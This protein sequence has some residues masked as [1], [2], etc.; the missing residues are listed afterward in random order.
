MGAERAQAILI[1][2]SFTWCQGSTPCGAL[3][4]GLTPQRGQAELGFEARGQ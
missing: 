4:L 1:P 2:C 3:I